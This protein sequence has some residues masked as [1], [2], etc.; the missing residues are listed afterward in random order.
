MNYCFFTKD[1]KDKLKIHERKYKKYT[2][3]LGSKKC[4]PYFNQF[5]LKAKHLVQIARISLKLAY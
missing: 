1:N 3:G 4:C 5:F 2:N